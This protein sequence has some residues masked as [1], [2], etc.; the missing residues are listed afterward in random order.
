MDENGQQLDRSSR[1]S[2]KTPGNLNG[3]R[4]SFSSMLVALLHSPKKESRMGRHVFPRLLA[5]TQKHKII[6][7]LAGIAGPAGR[8]DAGFRDLKLRSR[9]RLKVA[10]VVFSGGFLCG[11]KLA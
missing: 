5:G 9:S 11:H 4:K 6:E 10:L 2:R 1:F 3:L 8:G 7:S